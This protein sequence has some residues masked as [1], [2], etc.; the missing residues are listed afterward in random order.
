LSKKNF[1]LLL[2]YRMY[3]NIEVAIN[4]RSVIWMEG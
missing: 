1:A 4:D 2:F 3:Y